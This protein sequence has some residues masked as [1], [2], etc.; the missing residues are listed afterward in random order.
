VIRVGG[1]TE[2]EV[3]EKKDRVDDA[4][5]ATRAAVEEGISPGG[6]VA[7]LRS[8]KAL[9]NVKV[10]NHDQ[11]TGIDIVRK[12]IQAPARQIVDNAG[13]DGAVV[14]G[15]TDVFGSH[16]IHLRKRETA[17][18]ETSGQ[19]TTPRTSLSFMMRRSSPSILTSVPD[20][21]PKRMRSPA[22][23]SG[24]ELAGI[25]ATT[26]THSNDLALDHEAIVQRRECH[27]VPLHNTDPA[28]TDAGEG[29]VS[30]HLYRVPTN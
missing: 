29:V 7:L 2:V 24:D 28:A 27:V 30:T 6:G 25:I 20:H 23:T 10:E 11:K 8:I 16:V 5:N 1:A 12:A 4:L 22:L 15:K 26:G 17:C 13:A 21:F 3:K 18:E 9:E 19:S 14:V